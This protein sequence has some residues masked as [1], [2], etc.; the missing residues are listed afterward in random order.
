MKQYKYYAALLFAVLLTIG[1]VACSSDSDDT[2]DPEPTPTGDEMV[3]NDLGYLQNAIIEVDSLGNFMSRVCGAVLYENEPHH[4]FIGVDSKA[5]AEEMFCGWLAPDVV[6]TPTANGLSAPLTDEEGRAQGTVYFAAA[7]ASGQVAE[8]TAS[9]DTRLLHFNKITFLLN[10]AWPVNAA[11]KVFHLGDVITYSPASIRGCLKKEDQTLKWVCIRETGNGVPLMFVTITNSDQYPQ[12]GEGN[13]QSTDE[14]YS[15]SILRS[16]YCPAEA[17]AKAIAKIMDSDWAYWLETF[18]A[19]GIPMASDTPYWIDKTTGFLM[20]TYHCAVDF[21]KGNITKVYGGRKRFVLK[22][23]W[24]DDSAIESSLVGTDGSAGHQNEEYYHLFDGANNTKWCSYVGWRKDG[25]W[26]VE[27]FA[28]IPIK[29]VG[30]KIT[31][32][33][34]AEKYPGRNPKKWRLL[35]RDYD[36]EPWTEIA[37]ETDGKLPNVNGYT[38]SYSIPKPEKFMYYRWEISECDNGSTMQVSNFSFVF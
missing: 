16:S 21:P 23:D 2:P 31:T 25:V 4:L 9:A 38:K 12:G 13:Y 1:F 26:F 11:A 19:Q 6:I 33:S 34:D 32:A 37:S 17:K 14:R 36:D 30:Y 3:F 20:F 29:P 18:K 22:I 15:S 7:T 8:V 35:A 27:F 10:S 24:L 28:N 5:E